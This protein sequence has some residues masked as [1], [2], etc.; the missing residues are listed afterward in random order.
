MKSLKELLVLGLIIYLASLWVNKSPDKF[1]FLG[2]EFGVKMNH[3]IK[4]GPRGAPMMYPELDQFYE[5]YFPNQ[6]FKKVFIAVTY[7][8]L[9]NLTSPG[10]VFTEEGIVWGAMFSSDNDDEEYGESDFNK[11]KNYCEKKY[12]AKVISSKKNVTPI[13]DGKNLTKY[14]AYLI[15][16]ENI[17]IEVLVSDGFAFGGKFVVIRD[18][19]VLKKLGN[20]KMKLKVDKALKDMLEISKRK[21]D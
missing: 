14:T 8:D 10:D 6:E 2:L 4:D 12:K 18:Y 7:N 5:I 17:L 19:G 15:A 1:E 21:I 3:R 9:K 16:N 11:L 20:D 13:G